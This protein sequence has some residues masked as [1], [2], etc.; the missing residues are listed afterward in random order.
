MTEAS[1]LSD[2]EILSGPRPG[3][4]SSIG[5]TASELHEKSSHRERFSE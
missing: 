4:L 2:T 3:N 1:S 5:Q